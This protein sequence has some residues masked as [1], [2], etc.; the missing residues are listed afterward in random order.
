MLASPISLAFAE[1]YVCLQAPARILPC[2]NLVYRA[3][4]DPETNQNRLFCFC[5]QDFERILKT[6][7][8]D[9]EFILNKMEWRQIVAESGYTDAQLKSMIKR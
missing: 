2:E 5:R 1:N 8:T 4:K 3:V 7:V 9:E 6:D